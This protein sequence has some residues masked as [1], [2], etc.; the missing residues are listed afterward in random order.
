MKLYLIF[1]LLFILEFDA[2]SQNL[3]VENRDTSFINTID[4]YK[5]VVENYNYSDTV[6]NEFAEYYIKTSFESHKIRMKEL[7][8]ISLTSKIKSEQ[9]LFRILSLPTFYHPVCFTISNKYNRTYLHWTIGKGFGGYEP[10]GVKGKGV[11]KMSKNDWDYFKQLIDIASLDTLPLAS[12][13]Q[14]TDGIS[15]II[16][17]NIDDNYKIYFSNILSKKIEDGYALLLLISGVKTKKITHFYDS[18]E[19]RLF[20]KNNTLIDLNPIREN[21]VANLNQHFQDNLLNKDYCFD[22]GLYVKINSREKIKSVKYIPY[23]LPHRSLED[24]FDYFED[25]Y[26]DRKF[27]RAVKKSLKN[28][29]FPGLN[30][31]NKIWVPVYIKYN[32]NKKILEV[33]KK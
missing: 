13:L 18:D 29:D 9:Y 2:F 16:E 15:W 12:Y 21:I 5:I 3:I 25:N 7:K 31:S 6:Q 26:L 32:E 24:R 23:L 22:C 30:I 11:V 33:Y 27:R 1:G 10:K 19:I 14:M 8:E 17:S 4:N 20:D 28:Q